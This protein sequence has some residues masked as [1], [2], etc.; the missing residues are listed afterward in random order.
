MAVLNVGEMILDLDSVADSEA[1]LLAAHAIVETDTDEYRLANYDE[2]YGTSASPIRAPELLYG[3]MS[4][5]AQL[6]E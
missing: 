2:M 4:I 3:V 5:L 6:T 1:D